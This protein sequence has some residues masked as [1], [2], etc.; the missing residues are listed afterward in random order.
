MVLTFLCDFSMLWFHTCYVWS[1]PLWSFI[2]LFNEHFLPHNRQCKLV[3]DI[4]HDSG[5]FAFCISPLNGGTLK[6]GN[7]LNLKFQGRMINVQLKNTL[8][9]SWI[10]LKQPLN[11]KIITLHGLLIKFSNKF[12]KLSKFHLVLPMKKKTTR[13]YIDCYYHIKEIKVVI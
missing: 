7:T 2:L 11:T 8:K 9:K 5:H 10:T 6:I 3:Q 12:N 13:I 4:S 1:L